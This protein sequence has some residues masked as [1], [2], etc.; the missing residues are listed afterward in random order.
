[1]PHASEGGTGGT[2]DRRH[3]WSGAYRA[4]AWWLPL[5][6]IVVDV[7]VDLTL[8]RSREPLSFLLVGA[9]PLAAATRSPR[10]T[11]G[12]T[13]ACLGL[14]IWLASLR[15]GHLMEEHHVTVYATTALIGAASVALSWQRS[16]AEASLVRA[17]SIAEAIQMTLLRPFPKR[18]GQVR[19][20]GF[21]KA[22]EGGALV[23]GDLYD[24]C[25]TPFGVRVVLGDVRGKGL[26]AV[27]TVAA[28]LGSFRVCAHE[29]PDLSRLAEHMEL[30]VAR[31]AGA[32]AGD[33][34]LF[35]TALILEF[36][37]GGGSVRIVDRGHPSPLLLTADGPRRLRTVPYL[38]LGLGELGL[39][40][41][42]IT[43]HPLRAGEVVLLYTDGVSE[44]RNARGEFYPVLDRLTDRFGDGHRTPDPDALVSFIRTETDNWS[45]GAD[46]DRAV[47]ALS[48]G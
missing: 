26:D 24:L 7:V 33:E 11:A 28:V 6:L 25:E 42:E 29:W 9:P 3:L 8:L 2:E 37:P 15:P 34:E 32:S 31:N 27:Q 36:P 19:A 47:I 14:E 12:I 48:L 35:V 5:L 21:Y 40:R 4:W 45:A 23:G 1:M 13:L 39:D 38:P 22:G 20:A 30:S 16:K 10:H 44:A 43:T 46:D 41:A 17:R 18:L